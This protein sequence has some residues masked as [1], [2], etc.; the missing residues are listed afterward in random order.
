MS[1]RLDALAGARR[2]AIMACNEVSVEQGEVVVRLRQPVQALVDRVEALV[3]A[4]RGRRVLHCGCADAP[5]TA[6]RL[7]EGTLLHADLEAVARECVGTDHD[8]AAL[9]VLRARFPGARFHAGDI[10]RAGEWRDLLGDFDV[11]VAGEVL[12]HLDRPFDALSQLAG[13]LRPDGTLVVTVPNAFS[14][15]GIVR[16]L[17]GVERVHRDHVAYYSPGTLA[18]L[19]R[20][21]GLRVRRLT[22]YVRR[23]PRPWMAALA[24]PLPALLRRAPLLA[25]G[26]IAEL[27]RE[28]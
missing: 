21:A 15:K 9:D 16:A 5:L 22:G 26:L 4:C 19:A 3:E 11:I 14:L 10:T 13:L 25:E 23:P 2:S 27:V 8:A 1:A 17:A 24:A 18:E 20:R 7:A 6:R 28:A 12:E